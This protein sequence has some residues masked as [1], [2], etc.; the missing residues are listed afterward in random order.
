MGSSI[1][2]PSKVSTARNAI[3]IGI[4]HSITGT[5]S[6]SEVSVKDATLLAI[7][8]INTAG[9]VLGCPLEPI[10]EDGESDLQTFAQKAKQLLLE[11]QVAVVFGCWTSA[12]RKAVLPVFEQ[13]NG[14]LFYPVQYEGLEQ[15][16]NIFYTGAAPN[17]QII[18][19]IN[20]L[21]SQG[22]RKIFL[23]GSDYIFPR[24]ANLIV[25]AQL[26]VYDGELV[27]EEYI[28]LGSMDVSATIAH[29]QAIK[30]DAIFNTLNGDT[31]IAF[32]QK[33]RE[34]GITPEQLPIMSVSIAEEEVRAIG[35]EN[36]ANHLVVWNYF[37]T[38][39][40]PEN[41]SFVS[42]YQAKYG[43]NRVTD[44]P[45]E[46]AYFGVYLWKKAVEKAGTIEVNKVRKAAKNIE[47]TAPSGLVKIDAKTQHTWKTVRIGKVRLDGQIEEIYNSAKPIQPDPFLK[48]YVWARALYPRGLG[49]GTR[50]SLMGLFAALVL[51][52]WMAVGVGWVGTTQMKQDL[53]AIAMSG[54]NTARLLAGAAMAAVNQTECLLLLAL[55]LS[56]LTGIFSLLLVYRILRNLTLV[57][58]TAQLMAS[59]DFT[60]RSPIISND[61]IGVLSSTLNTMAQQIGSL[62]KA[63]EVKN[64]QLE[65]RTQEL[66]IAAYAAQ[67]ASRAKSTFLANMSHELRTPLNAIIGYSELLQEDANNLA[68][69]NLFDDLKNINIA[70]KQLLSII[71]DI[72]DISKIEA[73]KMD[74]FLEDF[75]L[76]ELIEEIAIT[77]QPLITKNDN[78]LITNCE[79]NLGKIHADLAKLRQILF[80]L[81][82]NAAKFTHR[83]KITLEV[84]LSPSI[85]INSDTPKNLN[86][87]TE[88]FIIFQVKDTGIGMT[89]QQI[90]KLFEPFSQADNSTTRKY[91]GTGLGL[92][93][94]QKFC[95]M[96]GGDIT[97]E[98]LVDCGSTFTICLPINVQNEKEFVDVQESEKIAFDQDQK[99]SVAPSCVLLNHGFISPLSLSDYSN[100]QDG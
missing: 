92:T 87:A 34:I 72:L 65:D 70:G 83:G 58:Q 13:L 38:V 21:L 74:I 63:V 46:A 37:Q 98:S 61:A 40:T 78:V 84:K 56:W 33:W 82:S 81:L 22:K 36:I 49:V 68:D 64:H 85:V 42:A 32:F 45:I 18:P 69:D 76:S 7:E 79:E 6:M 4:L 26:A 29:I 17:Q 90:S 50:V 5:M 91:G 99:V 60:V 51:I 2:Y 100:R 75:E 97:V 94:S 66:E 31:N 3:K 73:G 15:S 77:V 93:I 1:I 88:K 12:S 89:P 52:A 28:A 35:P 54:D 71:S 20:Y 48:N 80:N 30:P 47:F 27:G 16:P 86:L 43:Q 39:D 96:M 11:K 23:M 59:G 53:I 95:Q 41:K 24:T 25:K 9:G 8:E 67:S 10:I 57:R 62:F 14:L 55:I 19:G 44:D